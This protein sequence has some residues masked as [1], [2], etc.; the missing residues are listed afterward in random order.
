MRK[1]VLGRTP[2]LCRTAT[3][4]LSQWKAVWPQTTASDLEPSPCRARGRRVE[5]VTLTIPTGTTPWLGGTEPSPQLRNS[6]DLTCQRNSDRLLL[7]DSSPL[8]LLAFSYNRLAFL[9]TAMIEPSTT[10]S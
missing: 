10:M 1:M 9:N 3:A 2:I 8:N 6:S 4:S 7:E 5:R